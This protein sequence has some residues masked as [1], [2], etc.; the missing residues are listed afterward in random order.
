MRKI[1]I[2]IFGLL[3]TVIAFSQ[4]KLPN[5]KIGKNETEITLFNLQDNRMGF[6]NREALGGQIV[7]RMSWKKNTKIGIGVLLAADYDDYN[8]LRSNVF[9]Y[10]AAFADVTQFIGK[11]QKWSVGVQAGHGIYKREYKTDNFVE[12]GFNKW[13]GG[14]YYTF[15]VSYRAIISKKILIIVSSFSGIRNFRQRS[16]FEHYSPPSIYRYKSIEEHD[17]LGLRLGIV[18]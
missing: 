17:G 1:C 16:V 15:A 13:T 9:A 12:K 8:R 5:T 4:K 14:M 18:F 10:G 3:L 11:R 7:Y 2:L 6:D